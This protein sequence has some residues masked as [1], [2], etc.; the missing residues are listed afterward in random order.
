MPLLRGHVLTLSFANVGELLA[1]PIVKS[2]GDARRQ[3]WT[4]AIRTNFVV[5]P[6]NIAVAELWAPLHVRYR[7]HLQR[8]GAND[9]WVAASAMAANPPHPLATNNLSDFQKIA[10]D[11][12]LTLIHPSLPDGAVLETVEPE[13][14]IPTES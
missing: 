1:L 8:G 7:G 13:Q 3:A 9:L 6:F 4:D 10:A 12:P 5:L 14:S 11:C 2:W